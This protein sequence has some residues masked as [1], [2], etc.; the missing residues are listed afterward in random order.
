MEYIPNYPI[1]AYRID[2]EVMGNE[3]FKSFVEVSKTKIDHI[4]FVFIDSYNRILFDIQMLTAL[5]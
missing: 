2:E 4:E 3:D 1:A 5:T